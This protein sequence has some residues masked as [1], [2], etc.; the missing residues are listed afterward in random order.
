M[1]SPF[2]WLNQDPHNAHY[3]LIPH[4]SFTHTM[5]QNDG[6]GHWRFRFNLEFGHVLEHFG[7]MLENHGEIPHIS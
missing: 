3:P 2:Y 6:L 4:D 5:I 7:F 1:T